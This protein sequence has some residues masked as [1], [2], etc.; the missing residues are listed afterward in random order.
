M[1][2]GV[3]VF[4]VHRSHP[5]CAAGD[6]DHAGVAAVDGHPPQQQPGQREVAEVVGGHLGLEAVAGASERRGHDPASSTSTSSRSDGEF[7]GSRVDVVKWP[8]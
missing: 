4:E 1:S 8:R 2:N 6:G 3:E 5:V 7:V